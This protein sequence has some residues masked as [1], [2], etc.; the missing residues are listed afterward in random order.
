MSKRTFIIA[1]AIW[2]ALII[3]AG[4]VYPQ[5]SFTETNTPE[6]DT[7]V[8]PFSGM[9]VNPRADVE[10]TEVSMQATVTP[11]PVVNNINVD[12]P[13]QPAPVVEVTNEGVDVDGVIDIFVDLFDF[14]KLSAAGVSFVVVA[15]QIIKEL[16]AGAVGHNIPT[17]AV[18]ILQVVLSVI[19]IAGT[20]F[21]VLGGATP[22][23]VDI[24]LQ[25]I[26]NLLPGIL[27]VI[28]G[29]HFV[30]KFGHNQSV[31]GVGRGS[32]S[33]TRKTPTEPTKTVG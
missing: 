2:F 12:V 8:I 18:R 23:Q 16:Y 22:E 5:G 1:G 11:E 25:S 24:T 4:Q 14:T 20:Q 30:Y 9:Q 33:P 10:P 32:S 19:V 7:V 26:M 15:L 17:R 21:A 3:G 13:E 27:T 29:A 28:F 31:P 6:P